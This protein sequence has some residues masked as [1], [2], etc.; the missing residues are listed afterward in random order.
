MPSFLIRCPAI[1]VSWVVAMSGATACNSVPDLSW[2]GTSPDAGD[3]MNGGGAP[4]AGG[5]V[6]A[7]PPVAIRSSSVAITDTRI[8]NLAAMSGAAVS[9]HLIDDRTASVPALPGFDT[10]PPIGTCNI[11]VYDDAAGES[12]PTIADEG[13]I[14][15]SGTAN[16]EF[17]CSFSGG[18]YLCQST[19]EAI[20]GGT[21]GNAAGGTLN[22]SG[23]FLLSGASFGAEMQGMEIQLTGFMDGLGRPV[24]GVFPILEVADPDTLMLGRVPASSVAT[25]VATYTTYVGRSPVPGASGFNFLDGGEAAVLIHKDGTALAPQFDVTLYASGEG[26]ALAGIQPHQ[27]PAVASPVTFTCEGEGGNCGAPGAGGQTGVMLV[28]GATTD[29]LPAGTDDGVTMEKPVARHAVFT[30]M[31]LENSVSIPAEVVEAILATSPARIRVTVSRLRFEP[32]ADTSAGTSTSV[33]LGH[34]L[35]GFTTIATP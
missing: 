11:T 4:D 28:E 31:S 17:A 24:D 32:I 23:Q 22:V 21:D 34:S 29:A 15:V 5:T 14:T 33:V 6:D 27:F 30:C 3:D 13:A 8:T 25:P 9:I 16:G 20:R 18:E 7:A 12:E 26:F 2:P 10:D 19:S 35:T 1:L